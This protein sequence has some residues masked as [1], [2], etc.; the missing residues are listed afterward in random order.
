MLHSKRYLATAAALAIGAVACGGA[1]AQQQQTNGQDRQQ[2]YPQLRRQLVQAQRQHAGIPLLPAA[3]IVNRPLV[4]RDGRSAGHIQQLIIDTNNGVV[5]YVIVAGGGGFNLNGDLVAVPWSA[6]RQPNGQGA[7]ALQITDRQLLNAPRISPNDLQSV[8]GSSWRN[9]V[10]GFWGVPYPYARSWA[11]YR[12]YRGGGTVGNGN[13]NNGANN[14]YANNGNG[15]SYANNAN[16]SGNRNANNSATASNGGN[17]NSGNSNSNGNGDALSVNG[18]G[19]VAELRK[20]STV[21]PQQLRAAG[22]WGENG[23][24]I[25]AINQVMIDTRNGHVAYVLIQR[26]GFLG[27]NPV[28]YP[29]PLQALRWVSGPYG[30]A[31]NGSRNGN[32]RNNGNNGRYAANGYNGNAGYNR[33]YGPGYYGGWGWGYGGNGGYGLHLTVSTQALNN[34]P[35]VPVNTSHLTR[36]APPRDLALLYRDFGVQPYWNRNSAG[37]TGMGGNAR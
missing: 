37:T 8:A 25:G 35:P 33:P 26:G 15:N 36:Y 20:A 5:E 16:N 14:G 22:V 17:N 9:R 11:G 7:I 4:D 34:L 29:V 12:A 3:D 19:V 27:L 30:T 24:P 31:A 18:S 28:W 23:T 1:Q 6:L 10:Y 2:Q 13:G 21:E 32:N